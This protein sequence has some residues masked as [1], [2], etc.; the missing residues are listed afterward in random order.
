MRIEILPSA[1]KHGITEAEIRTVIAYPDLRVTLASRTIDFDSAPVLH[2]GRPDSNE[3]HLEVI[4]DLIDPTN[5]IAF[6][7]MMLRQKLVESLDLTLL[8]TPEYGPQRRR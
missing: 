4:A 8:F 5:A 1:L 3:P 7:A 2:I 6:H